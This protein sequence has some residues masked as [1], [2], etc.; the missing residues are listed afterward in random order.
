M[1]TRSQQLLETN[2][3]AAIVEK[4]RHAV[5]TGYLASSN[6]NF[7]LPNRSK[8]TPLETDM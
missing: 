8:S 3:D 1:A 6:E 4:P 7:F 2:F 5:T